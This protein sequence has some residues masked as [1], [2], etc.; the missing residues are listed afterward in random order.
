MEK[1]ALGGNRVSLIFNADYRENSPVDMAVKAIL[2]R[3]RA[4]HDIHLL[5]EDVKRKFC[6]K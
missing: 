6:L 3:A 4:V 5:K 2:D 1:I